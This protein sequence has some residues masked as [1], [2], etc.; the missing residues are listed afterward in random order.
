MMDDGIITEFQYL[1]PPS[2]W[3]VSWIGQSATRSNPT[4]K[5][6]PSGHPS[7]TADIRLP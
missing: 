1:F 6:A 5:A 7:V 4:L 3:N 2:F